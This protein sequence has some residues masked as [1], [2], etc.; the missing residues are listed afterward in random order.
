MSLT[1]LIATYRLTTPMFCAGA[2]QKA[3]AELRPASFKG[4]LRFW[5]RAIA[6]AEYEGNVDAVR[7]AEA[8]L[9]GS[10]EAGQARVLLSI[11]E[12]GHGYVPMKSGAPLGSGRAYL[13]GLGLAEPK[14]GNT[15]TKRFA[16]PAGVKFSVHL[17]FK[18]SLEK[19][20]YELLVDA[21][22]C[23]GIFG[24]LGARSRRGFGSL[25]LER[26]T[27]NEGDIWTV[28]K[29]LNTLKATIT[30][31]LSRRS[32]NLPL[33]PY[34]AFSN[35]T[36]VILLPANHSNPER[37]HE[38]LGRAFLHFR[39]YGQNVGGERL[40]A[41]KKSLKIFA[42]D[43]H[44]MHDVATTH[45]K[46]WTEPPSRAAFGLPHNYYFK[47]AMSSVKVNGEE[48][49]RRASPLL[50]H[51][52]HIGDSFPVAIACFLPA[53]FLPTPWLRISSK[54]SG[55]LEAK[56]P[57]PDDFWMPI[58]RFCDALLGRN[59]DDLC[60]KFPGAIEVKP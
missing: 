2:D 55:D 31:I 36:R 35:N 23:A 7:N 15:Q 16:V 14:G 29:D 28:P 11:R 1:R 19:G 9:F 17:L 13:A 37:L 38:S 60:E 5:Y 53:R 40:V 56:L 48:A 43:H 52:H 21:L 25:S 24:G 18:E 39:S 50:L 32:C 51:I 10:T 6:L 58:N 22:I 59:S 54:K 45:V 12:E 34:T 26:L 30:R 49:K 27:L 20:P 4:I 33:P 41:G 42:D 3:A 44:D 47:Q 46:E 57:K 8:D